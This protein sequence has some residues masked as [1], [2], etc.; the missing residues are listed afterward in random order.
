MRELYQLLTELQPTDQLFLI[1]ISLS[2]LCSNMSV[3]PATHTGILLPFTNPTI[4]PLLHILIASKEANNWCFTDTLSVR[5]GNAWLTSRQKFTQ[6][7]GG[8]HGTPAE[9][10]SPF[11]QDACHTYFNHSKVYSPLHCSRVEQLRTC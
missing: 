9:F 10:T 11:S 2:I 5:V 6:M 1:R 7:R 4:L 3:H 8:P